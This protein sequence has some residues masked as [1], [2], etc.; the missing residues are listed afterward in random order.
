DQMAVHLPLS[1]EAQDE[2]RNL[3]AAGRNL[4]KPATGD[5]VTAPTNDF[6][7]G[8]YYLTRENTGAKGVG[9]AFVSLDEANMAYENDIVSLHAPVRIGD[10]Q[11]TLGRMIFNNALGGEVDYV[12]ETLNKKKL[13][14]VIE[15]ILEKGDIEKTAFI[16][17]NLKLL[18][19][20][21]ATRSGITWSIADL[22]V[23]KEKK[24]IMRKAESQVMAIREQYQEG[25]LTDAERRVRVVSVWEKT[26][27][28]L[29]KLVTIALDKDNSVY[30]IIDAGARGSWNQSTQM[31]GMKGLV[32]NPKG[33]LIELPIKS[34]FKE[35]LGVIE[36]FISTH[37]ARK[38]TTDTALKT[39]QAG[40]LTRRLV[41]VSQDITIKQEDCRA[42]E[43]LEIFRED[44]EKF[45]HSFA[46]R[47]F[48]RIA[49][50]DIRVDRKIVVRSGEVIDK[51]IA[52]AIDASGVPSIKVRSPI[53]CKTLYGLCKKC[54]GLD[55]GNNEMVKM[56][57]VVGVVAAQSIGEPGT[58]LTMRTFHIGG[59]AGADITHGLPRVEELFEVRPPKG[60]AI[61]A[62]QDAVVANIE[63]H[64]NSK[65]ITLSFAGEGR[66]KGKRRKM[67]KEMEFTV[68]RSV[69]LNVNIGDKVGAGEQLSEGN[70]DLR[71]LLEFRGEGAVIRHIVSE[72]QKIYTAEG[73]SI[74][75]KH[76]EVIVRQMFSRVRIK[77]AGD[78]P[79]LVMGE[80][81]EK[82]R[83]LEVNRELKKQG[84]TPAR[85][86]QLLLGITRVA[87]STE[88]FLS[89]ASFQDTARVL[90]KAAI[91]GKID[92]L[93]G[94]KENVIIGRLI[95]VGDPSERA[96]EP[97]PLDESTE[98][99]LS[100]E[101]EKAVS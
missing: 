49:L 9:K 87:L 98:T 48:S 19:Y 97:E 93:R 17:D 29:A 83:F 60:K 38:G 30:Q 57:A 40:Y 94:L 81:I 82:S 90:V 7:L 68:P 54:Y 76:I 52:E 91:E 26:K 18:G 25:L 100:E 10:R 85:A 28:E 32:Q 46:A 65:T 56:G 4:L 63:E 75:N 84:K 6:V 64:G 42:K 73:A 36:Y 20:D 72:V 79:N 21:M 58:Q 5:L 61:I 92:S 99:E 27:I 71:E 89:A 23:P 44:G 13:A 55:L 51:H 50:D 1:K 80:T 70:I 74:N 43:G 37:G 62:P 24:E 11:T 16:L 33:E 101:V 8:I 78:A 96:N 31:M 53:T 14:K 88:S 22:A 45:N 66:A 3:M 34:S 47:L 59:V 77:E 95:P 35:G 12:N 41:D 2:A 69:M 67:V 39:A 86:E 15:A